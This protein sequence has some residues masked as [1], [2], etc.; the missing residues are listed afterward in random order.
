MLNLLKKES[1]VNVLIVVAFYFGI[2]SE[3]HD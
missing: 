2:R 1:F 3:L